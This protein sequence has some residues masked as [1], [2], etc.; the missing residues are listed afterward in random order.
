[1]RARHGGGFVSGGWIG[2]DLGAVFPR[3][4][5]VAMGECLR[6]P[7]PPWVKAWAAGRRGG[8]VEGL[9]GVGDVGGLTRRNIMKQ[10]MRAAALAALAWV[11]LSSVAA[12]G[13]RDSGTFSNLPSDGWGAC[14][15]GGATPQIPITGTYKVHALVVSGQLTR[16]TPGTCESEATLRVIDVS[17][18]TQLLTIAPFSTCSDQVSSVSA[19]IAKLPRP[20]EVNPGTQLYIVPSETFN[21]SDGSVDAMWDTLTVTLDDGPPPWTEVTDLGALR[22]PSMSLLNQVVPASAVRWYRFTLPAPAA[23]LGSFGTMF[24]D[25]DTEGSPAADMML[26]LFD[27]DGRLVA[28]DDDAGSYYTPQLTFGAAPP[29]P[30]VGDGLPYD[31]R[32]GTLESGMYYLAVAPYPMVVGPVCWEVNTSVTTPVLTRL[33]VHTN[34]NFSPYCKGDF[35]KTGMT[36]TQDIFDFLNAWFAGCP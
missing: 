36:E 32:S 31:N 10:R 30:A 9:R 14:G 11:A 33:N 3:N 1:M 18:G 16:A 22:E 7:E 21:D 17:T 13:P 24:I 26:A 29:R 5:S 27:T 23:D 19:Y 35:N 34:I 8:G 12:A 2:A 4:L 28:W 20:I 25:I 15:T 6:A